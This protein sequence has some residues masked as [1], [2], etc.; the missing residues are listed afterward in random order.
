MT[1]KQYADLKRCALAVAT[2]DECGRT[3]LSDDEAAY[4]HDCES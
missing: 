4:G 3:D 1:R 2:C